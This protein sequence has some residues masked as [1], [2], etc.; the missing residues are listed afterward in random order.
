MD[1]LN[2][3]AI[4]LVDEALE[5]ATELNV[6]GFDLENEAT[7]L[8]FGVDFDGGIE[9]GLLL[10]EIQT[11]GLATLGRDLDVVGGAP[12]PYVEVSTDQPALSLLCSQKAG[13]ELSTDDFEGLGSGPA[14]AL[15]AE[16]DEFRHIGYSDAFDLT[17]LA[18]ESDEVPTEAIADQ[19][20]N[21]TGLDPNGV[22]LLAYSS[23]SIVGSVVNAARA[24]ELATFRLWELGYDPMDVVSATGRAPV[25]PVAADERTAIGRTNDAI[26]YGGSAHLVVTADD[27]RFDHVASSAG[28]EYGRPFVDIFDESGWAL[29]EVPTD[30]FAP[31]QVTVDVVGGPTHVVGERNDDVLAESF[32]LR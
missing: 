6:G 19:V 30:L 22:F 29:N 32:G 1:S 25:A 4:E 9:A 16:E 8:D 11:A 31:A 28:A 12:I 15:V 17:V 2:R 5:Y 10:A 14:R 20:A 3:L 23:A 7:V 13:W 26:A 24:A 21:R 18:I 27:E